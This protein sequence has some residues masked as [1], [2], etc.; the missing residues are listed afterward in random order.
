M[1]TIYI[2]DL[3][4]SCV[5]GINDWERIIQQEVK[6]H[7]DLEIDLHNAGTQD[8]IKSTVDYKQIRDR[9]EAA[10]TQSRCYLIEALAEQVAAVCLQDQRVKGVHICVEKPGALRNT[11]TVGVKLSRSRD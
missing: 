10:V 6:I 7:V 11:G 4:C 8:N 9:I 2:R 1:D 5:I 3:R